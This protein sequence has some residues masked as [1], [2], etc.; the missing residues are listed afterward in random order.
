MAKRSTYKKVA[1][2]VKKAA[3]SVATTA[4]RAVKKVMPRK[5]AKRGRKAKKH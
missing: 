3:K 4:K 5:K 2:S 1:R